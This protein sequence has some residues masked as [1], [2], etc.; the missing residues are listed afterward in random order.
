LRD[1]SSRHLRPPTMAAGRRADSWPV[2]GLPVA[3]L[4]YSD[5]VPRWGVRSVTVHPRYR[6][7]CPH[8]PN[9]YRKTDSTGS[10]SWR[11]TGFGC[12]RIQNPGRRPTPRPAFGGARRTFSLGPRSTNLGSTALEHRMVIRGIGAVPQGEKEA[13]APACVSGRNHP[14]GARSPVKRLGR[15]WACF[16]GGDPRPQGLRAPRSAEAV[17][18]GSWRGQATG[19]QGWRTPK[20]GRAVTAHSGGCSATAR[21]VARRAI[22]TGRFYCR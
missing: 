20:V 16:R 17:Q 2:P 9:D 14:I 18:H 11:R 22:I 13:E 21:P 1:P 3:I 19:R 8:C 12:S 7:I 15:G 5:G 6:S 4:A 10:P